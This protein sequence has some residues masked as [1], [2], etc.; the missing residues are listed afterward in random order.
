MDDNR[1][2]KLF[3]GFPDYM[4]IVVLSFVGGY[5]DGA[6]YIKLYG[7]FTSSV[8]GNIVVSATSLLKYDLG[9]GTRLATTMF[10]GVGA[11]ISGL[12]VIRMQK[13]IKFD[14][15]MLATILLSIEILLLAV[16]T[17]VAVI[18]EYRDGSFPSIGHWQTAIIGSIIAMAMGVQSVTGVE[19]VLGSPSTTAMT[20]NIVR[21][22]VAAAQIA[23]LEGAALACQCSGGVTQNEACV[24]FVAFGDV[25]L[26]VLVFIAGAVAGA[27]VTLS[28]DLLSLAVPVVLLVM[29]MVS[30]LLARYAHRRGAQQNHVVHDHEPSNDL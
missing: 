27:A 14:V 19:M 13:S 30:V 8:T 6:G 18:L 2:R 20:A 5:V 23:S 10:F 29:M 24:L 17:V 9:V 22:F 1:R 7:L 4:G 21:A 12:L 28:I 3:Y 26:V 15:W 16:A 11:F 25:L